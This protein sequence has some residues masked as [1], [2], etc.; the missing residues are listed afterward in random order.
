MKD[1]VEKL[2]TDNEHGP[3]IIAYTL[4]EGVCCAGSGTR[5]IQG[6]GDA[7]LPA[8]KNLPGSRH[9][10]SSGDPETFHRHKS[11]RRAQSS[12]DSEFHQRR[13]G[14]GFYRVHTVMAFVALCPPTTP[15]TVGRY[16]G[17]VSRCG[18]V[19]RAA[20]MDLNSGAS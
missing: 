17:Q 2:G 4:N 18:T 10:P 11:T 5:G 14:P 13:A 16:L 1:S 15:L 20:T 3:G 8:L 12:I 7:K 9:T 19:R 6:S